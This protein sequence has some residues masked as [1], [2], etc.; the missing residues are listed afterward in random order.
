MNIDP[1][2]LLGAMVLEEGQAWGQVAH[3]FQRTDAEAVVR[4]PS[5]GTSSCGAEA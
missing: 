5:A 4:G 2:D 1:L 3:P